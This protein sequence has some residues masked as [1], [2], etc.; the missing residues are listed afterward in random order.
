LLL[1]P[2]A[3]LRSRENPLTFLSG[4]VA[5]AAS[6]FSSSYYLVGI[7]LRLSFPIE[8]GA[9]DPIFPGRASPGT[10]LDVF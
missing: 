4:I 7:P 1:Y 3:L 9:P 8:G 2:F 5:E 10:P 6:Y